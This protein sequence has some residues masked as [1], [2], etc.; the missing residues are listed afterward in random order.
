MV[1]KVSQKKN[2]SSIQVIK[3]LKVLL[4]GNY[5]MNELIQILNN[6]EEEPVFN[7]SVISKY[8]NTCRFCGINI[9]KIN[10]KYYVSCLPFGLELSLSDMDLIK[11]MQTVVNTNFS[12]RWAKLF[13]KL[14]DKLNR[15]SVANITNVN[16][17]EFNFSFELFEQA[18]AQKRKIK[19][20]FKNKDELECIPLDIEQINEKTFFNVYNKRIR[21]I[22]INRLSG[23]QISHNT[24]IEPF[25]SNLSVTFKLKGA[26]AKRYEARENETVQQCSD[27]SIMVT[28]RNE[29]E[30]CLISRLLRYDDKCEII[31][32]VLFREKMKNVLNNMLGNYGET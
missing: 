2:L 4:Q 6:D 16:K 15:Y 19:L 30:E 8:I 7:N 11:H 25:D 24:Y 10:N 20:L 29:N 9:P 32:P 23:I 21:Q 17:N 22:D 18:V 13:E 14:T 3:T 26:L 27:G 1:S 5:A 12:A 28:N 31:T